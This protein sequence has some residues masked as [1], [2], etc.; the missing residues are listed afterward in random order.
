MKWSVFVAFVLI[1]RAQQS[2]AESVASPKSV[3]SVAFCDDFE[4]QG[5]ATFQISAKSL[6]PVDGRFFF[7]T[8]IDPSR[9]NQRYDLPVFIPQKGVKYIQVFSTSGE[10][11]C[12]KLYPW[13]PAPLLSWQQT[14]RLHAVQKKKPL[15][16]PAKSSNPS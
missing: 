6:E 9:G 16:H 1:L 8:G 14:S 12:L 7:A 10:D 5:K 3:V 13:T 2:D 11:L 15:P 4:A